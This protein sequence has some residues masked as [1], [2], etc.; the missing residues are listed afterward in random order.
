MVSLDIHTRAII[1]A[2]AFALGIGSGWLEGG[3]SSAKA[4]ERN[5][6]V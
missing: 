2:R 6:Q 3:S 4:H 1:G 5:E